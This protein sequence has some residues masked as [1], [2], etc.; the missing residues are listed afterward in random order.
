MDYTIEAKDGL[1]YTGK[2]L[3]LEEYGENIRVE[4]DGNFGVLV[5]A[6]IEQDGVLVFCKKGSITKVC[7]SGYVE[8]EPLGRDE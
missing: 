8:T 6:T 2:A 1:I 5:A 3:A 7:A 4:N